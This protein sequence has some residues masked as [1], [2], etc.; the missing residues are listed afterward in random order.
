[1]KAGR[2]GP[3]AQR[4]RTG[5]FGLAAGLRPRP[6]HPA[7]R[8]LLCTGRPFRQWPQAAGGQTDNAPA[9]LT[10]MPPAPGG[11]GP[12]RGLRWL[13]QWST[14]LVDVLSFGVL[15]DDSCRAE[16]E[17]HDLM[18][19][20]DGVLRSTEIVPA[21]AARLSGRL[22]APLRLLLSGL[23]ERRPVR[24]GERAVT[25]PLMGTGW[26]HPSRPAGSRPIPPHPGRSQLTSPDGW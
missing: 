8:T 21:L 20:Y 16:R 1:M 17:H 19:A 3:G 25:L 12:Q 23:V 4:M 22:I 13:S 11:S 7:K 26:E 14:P 15:S 10:H 9:P 2:P 24:P 6:G 18:H 5:R